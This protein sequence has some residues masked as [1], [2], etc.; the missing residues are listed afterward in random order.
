L[1]SEEEISII[2]AVHRV[3]ND[4]VQ[5]TFDNCNPVNADE[6]RGAAAPETDT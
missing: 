2:H 4:K 3:E 1:C 5:D 6:V